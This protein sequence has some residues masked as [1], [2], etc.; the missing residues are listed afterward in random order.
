[1]IQLII[2]YERGIKM[3]GATTRGLCKVCNGTISKHINI[4]KPLDHAYEE[5]N[6]RYTPGGKLV[7]IE[8]GI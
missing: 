6:Y 8:R 2:N 3:D 4:N 5:G 7:R 1:M